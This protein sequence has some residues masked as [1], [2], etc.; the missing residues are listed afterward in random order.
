MEADV[1]WELEHLDLCNQMAE[2]YRGGTTVPELTRM[3]G[4]SPV[5]IGSVL[6]R[7]GIDV[8]Y[9][10]QAFSSVDICHR[11]ALIYERHLQGANLRSIGT[12]FGLCRER[13]RQIVAGCRR[14]RRNSQHGLQA[15]DF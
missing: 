7:Y 5:W 13:V 12:E 2:Q 6:A 15:Q 11:D 1:I 8:G 4:G 9:K 14:Q 3:I 10:Q